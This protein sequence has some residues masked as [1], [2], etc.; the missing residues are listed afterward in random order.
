M[1]QKRQHS[2]ERLPED[3]SEFFRIPRRAQIVLPKLQ[4]RRS[5]VMFDLHAVKI[6][7]D[8]NLRDN[9]LS[10]QHSPPL[11]H[12]ENLDGKN[13]RGLSQLTFS[14]EKRSRF[15]LLHAP[16]LHHVRNPP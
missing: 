16:P 5:Q 4:H 13:I 6:H 15:P 1:A 8:F 12:V 7:R 11:L 10:V 3:W 14:E 2:R 9:V